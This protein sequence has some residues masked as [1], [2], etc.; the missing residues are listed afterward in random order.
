[1]PKPH[2]SKKLTQPRRAAHHA[3]PLLL[4]FPSLPLPLLPLADSPL[5]LAEA[6]PA[7]ENAD[8][9]PNARSSPGRGGAAS[10]GARGTAAGE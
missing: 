6:F 10:G 7:S 8:A 1:M 9:S 2:H 4:D 5:A 3:A